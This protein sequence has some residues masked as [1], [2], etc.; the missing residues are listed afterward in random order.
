MFVTPEGYSSKGLIVIIC[1]TRIIGDKFPSA[2]TFVLFNFWKAET[3]KNIKS[4][5][6]F[7]MRVCN[8]TYSWIYYFTR[9][10][11][12]CVYTYLYL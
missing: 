7:K 10:K 6:Y 1:V 8:N 4:L 5:K 3:Y 11:S 9:N 12:I 2:F